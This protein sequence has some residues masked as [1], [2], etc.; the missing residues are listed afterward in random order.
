[1]LVKDNLI[2]YI[3]AYFRQQTIV[4]NFPIEFAKNQTF[5]T[6]PFR[7]IRWDYFKTT[8]FAI[9]QMVIWIQIIHGREHSS[10]IGYLTTLDWSAEASFCGIAKWIMLRRRKNLAELL[11]LFVGFE[12]RNEN[13]KLFLLFYIQSKNKCKLRMLLKLQSWISHQSWKLGWQNFLS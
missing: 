4:G 13:C 5:V 3:K 1:M 6:R 11:N 8:L 12:Q 9:F 10:T 2:H 7:K